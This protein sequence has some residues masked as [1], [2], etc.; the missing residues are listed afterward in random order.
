MFAIRD[1]TP[2]DVPLILEFIRGLAHYEKL[3]HEV[4]ATEEQLRATL[5]ERRYAEVIIGEEEGVAVAF[6][7]FFHNYS[8]F[9]ARPGVYLE[10]LFVVPEAR[11]RGYGKA[12]LQRLAQIAV[13]RQC[14]R[15]E[16][17][18]LDWNEDAIAFYKKLGA[19]PMDEWTVFRVT[20]EAL[21][22][23]AS[24]REDRD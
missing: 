12:M 9:L 17:W 11:G 7:L 14:G 4:V 8:T 3:A 2:S 5:F 1:A 18:V 19:I 20:G 15:L 23:L 10:D 22:E 13:E 21:R 16:W 24:S 6:A